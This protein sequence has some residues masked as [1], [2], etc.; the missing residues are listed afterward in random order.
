MVLPAKMTGSSDVLR[1]LT[2]WLHRSY[3]L[4]HITVTPTPGLASPPKPTS[5]TAE[6]E[7]RPLEPRYEAKCFE[8]F[9][10]THAVYPYR[11][12]AGLLSYRFVFPVLTSPSRA[13]KSDSGSEAAFCGFVQY[14]TVRL[15]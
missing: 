4:F 12:L 13:S 9:T 1:L 3:G 7:Q 11:N 6:G 14:G 10:Y 15:L 5:H 2:I 8:R